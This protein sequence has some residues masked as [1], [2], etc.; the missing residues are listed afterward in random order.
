MRKED[1][2]DNVRG[3]LHEDRC[4]ATTERHYHSQEA[5]RSM[6]YLEDQRK[7]FGFS[8]AFVQRPAH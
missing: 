4:R 1:L 3:H 5:S 6:T 2:R 7:V 8:V